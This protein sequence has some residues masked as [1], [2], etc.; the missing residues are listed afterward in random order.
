MVRDCFF[1]KR[2]LSGRWV[3]KG[4]INKDR[5]KMGVGGEE[6]G[7]ACLSASASIPR[8]LSVA[9]VSFP[10]MVTRVDRA[11]KAAAW[12]VSV[13]PLSTLTRFSTLEAGGE[14]RPFLGAI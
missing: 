9:R 3:K 10:I 6:E 7:S 8:P 12:T 14:C 5:E 1:C 4:G 13:S 11:R 2:C